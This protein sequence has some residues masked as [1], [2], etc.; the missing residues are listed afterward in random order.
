MTEFAGAAMDA[1]GGE[2]DAS[3]GAAVE[4]AGGAAG[5]V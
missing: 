3:A 5:A 2:F 1:M 4:V